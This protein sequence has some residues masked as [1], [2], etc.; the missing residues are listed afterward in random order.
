MK[1]AFFVVKN[2]NLGGG[3][4]RYTQELGS[5]LVARG[6]EVTVYSMRHYGEA[7]IEFDGMRVIGVPSLPFRSMEKFSSA[8]AA[9]IY[10]IFYTKPD[11][12]HFHS[13]AAGSFAWLS[14][15]RGLPCVLQMHGLEWKRSRW[16]FMGSTILRLLEKGA[17]KQTKICT[18][19]SKVQCDF[20]EREYG[21]RMEYIPTGTE[22]KEKVAPK[23]ILQLGLKPKSHILFASRLVREKGAHYLIPAFRRLN[24]D[25]KLVIAGDAKGEGQYKQELYKLASNDPRIIFTGFVQGRMLAELFSNAYLYVQP[26]E[27]EGLSI[28]LWNGR[29][30]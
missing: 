27:I 10:S 23:K 24:T 15:I 5:R 12:A 7:P 2:I 11:I 17:L 21:I 30:F 26:S 14:R 8:A 1:I 22:I 13:V 9:A 29:M 25:C 19:V 20:F 18:A 3:I 16:G 4:E 28:A 6:H